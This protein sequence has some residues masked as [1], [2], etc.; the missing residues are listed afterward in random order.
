MPVRFGVVEASLTDD[1]PEEGATDGYVFRLVPVAK[2]YVVFAKDP[3]LEADWF[4]SFFPSCLVARTN[5][6]GYPL[7]RMLDRQGSL[8]PF[9]VSPVPNVYDDPPAIESTARD[10]WLSW[11]AEAPVDDERLMTLGLVADESY[12]MFWTYDRETFDRVVEDLDGDH[13]AA[14]T[15]YRF[16]RLRHAAR[17]DIDPMAIPT[18]SACERDKVARLLFTNGEGGYFLVQPDGAHAEQRAWQNTCRSGV[19]FDVTPRALRGMYAA[20]WTVRC[21]VHLRKATMEDW[22][23]LTRMGNVMEACAAEAPVPELERE[24][25]A[26]LLI[27]PHAGLSLVHAPY[28]RSTR[29]VPLARADEIDL[30]NRLRRY[31][32]RCGAAEVERTVFRRAILVS[33]EGE[34]WKAWA[35]SIRDSHRIAH[36]WHEL[37]DRT[38]HGV[39]IVER[40]QAALLDYFDMSRFAKLQGQAGLDREIARHR[41]AVE[42]A[43]SWVTAR[44]REILARECPNAEFLESLCF[45]VMHDDQSRAQAA[46]SDRYHDVAAAVRYPFFAEAALEDPT[47]WERLAPFVKYVAKIPGKAGSMMKRFYESHVREFKTHLADATLA[48]R[49]LNY[50]YR[51]HCTVEGNGVVSRQL[52]VDGAALRTRIELQTDRN[53]FVDF[54]EGRVWFSATGENPQ[55]Y[56]FV[57]ATNFDD[58]PR[59]ETRSRRGASYEVPP[60]IRPGQPVER[61]RY[62]WANDGTVRSYSVQLPADPHWTSRAVVPAWLKTFS[63]CMSFMFAIE[64][65]VEQLDDAEVKIRTYVDLGQGVLGLVGTFDSVYQAWRAGQRHGT[66][67]LVVRS[68]WID[69]VA[70]DTGRLA[71]LLSSALDLYDGFQV[72]VGQDEDLRTALR[73]QDG[74]MVTTMRIRGGLQFASGAFG[75]WALGAEVAGATVA[76]PLGTACFVLG[77]AV[78][79]VGGAVLL[80][81]N[82]QSRL[83]PFFDEVLEAKEREFRRRVGDDDVARDAGVHAPCITR[84]YMATLHARLAPPGTSADRRRATSTR[85]RNGLPRPR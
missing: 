24:I 10:G 84:Q 74:V 28:Q 68:E 38:F 13:R 5:A 34:E 20:E 69:R 47:T 36:P 50:L 46:L 82:G 57:F 2:A 81:Q 44:C 42:D 12:A 56:P 14:F 65:L 49:A 53:I 83:Q 66:S 41:A 26:S 79:A 52:L 21:A 77:I 3:S 30:V 33:P 54:Q 9:S 63:D 8:F 11:D 4:D 16:S 72:A 78:F 55:S 62:R 27:T 40:A 59:D 73:R 58:M 17:A 61:V 45:H 71:S 67:D 64:K 31:A 15:R 48:N 51:Y 85:S 76:A 80:V 60:R 22:N 39:R 32:Q 6:A 37:G 25:N 75:A 7:V 70:R 35:T 1:A 23:V 19:V 18:L 43:Q 29:T